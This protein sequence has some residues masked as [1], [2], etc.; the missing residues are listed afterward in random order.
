MA[1]WRAN[2]CRTAVGFSAAPW[3]DLLGE[4]AGSRRRFHKALRCHGRLLVH[5]QAVFDHLVGRCRDRLNISY[6][7]RSMIGPATPI[8][9]R[10][11]I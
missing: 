3:A 4:D 7:V 2:G 1:T 8:R 11:P 9:G 5:K 10:P 6:E